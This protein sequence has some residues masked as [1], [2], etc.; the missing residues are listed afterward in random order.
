MLPQ[1]AID[2]LRDYITSRD[3]FT[4]IAH[5]SP[6]GDALGSTLALLGLLRQLGKQAEAVC[7][8]GVPTLYRFLPL[9]DQLCTPERATGYPHVISVDCADLGRL[10]QAQPLFAQAASTYNIDHHPTNDAYAG[11]N[12]VDPTAAATGELIYRLALSLG[13][14]ITAELAACLYTALMTDTG[15]FSYSNTTGDTL[16]IAGALLDAGA[17]GYDL[18][19]RIYRNTP[20]CKLRLLGVA[21]DGIRL[22]EQNRIGM[23]SLTRAQVEACG[24]REEDTEGV[25]DYVRDI[26]TVEI[27]IFLKESGP[28]TW[29]VS[30]RAKRWANVGAMAARLGGG[31]HARA[32][33]YTAKGGPDTVWSQALAAAKEILL[34]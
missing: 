24:A 14:P 20:F 25:V 32:A 31:G 18:N 1:C 21:I 2:S 3:G 11:S 22:Y 29:K 27:A 30:L 26:D 12:A 34:P 23:A 16:R 13:S 17:D 33:G 4:I 19:L 6:D 10:G 8:D 5:I 9:A 28:E 15:N 7:A